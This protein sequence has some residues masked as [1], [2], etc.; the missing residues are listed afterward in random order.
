MS[1]SEIKEEWGITY[2]L[3]KL[4]GYERDHIV[5][6]YRESVRILGPRWWLRKK[7]GE[8]FSEFPLIGDPN[9]IRFVI[10]FTADLLEVENC[11][12]FDSLKDNLVRDLGD[13]SE[14]RSSL[15]NLNEVYKTRIAASL[16]QNG[17]HIEIDP[18]LPSGK[19]P[20]LLIELRDA[21]RVYLELKTIEQ[22][23]YR[24]KS[25]WGGSLKKRILNDF[26][27]ARKQLRGKDNNPKVIIIHIVRTVDKL[28]IREAIQSRLKEN[29][30][31][32]IS[33][34]LVVAREASTLHGKR[35]V[36]RLKDWIEHPNPTNPISVSP[37]NLIPFPRSLRHTYL[38]EL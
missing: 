8:Y 5:K 6:V 22:M 37:Q 21:T 34:V 28:D 3:E 10:P 27:S 19:K 1:W 26:E 2:D 20:D 18:L 17:L 13:I 14:D 23:S 30:N 31:R 4:G 12:G 32:S 35:K 11:K 15:S 9:F 25:K 7:K 24:R 36:E 29:L 16:R 38:S 33:A